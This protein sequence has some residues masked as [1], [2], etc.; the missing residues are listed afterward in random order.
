MRMKIPSQVQTWFRPVAGLEDLPLGWPAEPAAAVPELWPSTLVQFS[1]AAEE[2]VSGLSDTKR[3]TV[4]TEPTS[5]SAFG[6]LQLAY[7]SM[8]YGLLPG[9]EAR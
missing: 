3:P 9:V 2:L 8:R 1:A 5:P 7:F 4:P 6:V